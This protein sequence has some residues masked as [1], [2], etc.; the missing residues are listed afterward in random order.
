[1]KNSAGMPASMAFSKVSRINFWVV[2][3]SSW[4]PALSEVVDVMTPLLLVIGWTNCVGTN[5]LVLGCGCCR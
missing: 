3:S 5:V 4:R 2:S 1:M